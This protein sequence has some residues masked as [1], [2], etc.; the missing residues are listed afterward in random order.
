MSKIVFL[1]APAYGHINPT[2]AVTKELVDR[3]HQVIY[4]SFPEFKETILST[5]ATYREYRNCPKL[6]NNENL[7]ERLSYLYFFIVYATYTILDDLIADINI[8][9]PDLIIHDWLCFWGKCVCQV[10]KTPSVSSISVCLFT[11]Q[12]ISRRLLLKEVFQLRRK[13]IQYL[14]QTTRY[15]NKIRRKYTL[16]KQKILDTFMNISELNIVYTS[17]V[18]QISEKQFDDKRFKF[19]GP[20]LYNKAIDFIDYK[21]L[22]KPVIYISLGTILNTNIDFYHNCIEALKDWKGTVILSIG[23]KTKIQQ[24]KHIP[25]NFIIKNYVHQIELLKYTDIFITHGGMNSTQEGLFYGVPLIFYPSQIEQEIIWIQGEKK[26]CGI[27]LKKNSP[28][29]IKEA[30]RKISENPSYKIRCKMMADSL[31]IAWWYKK[32]ADDIDEFL[33]RVNY[34]I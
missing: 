11:L 20:S 14:I 15:Q 13:D 6:V 3:W 18:F 31:H 33:K 10:T 30:I 19:V 28:E 29:H 5:W 32:A 8:L 9:K 25:A 16:P 17:R 23:K 24:F 1:N 4:Y 27:L 12:A 7:M 21:L 2:L 34:P 26:W 22:K